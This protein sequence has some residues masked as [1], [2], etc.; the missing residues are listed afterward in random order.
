MRF[1]TQRQIQDQFLKV[2]VVILGLEI[3]VQRVLPLSKLF[4]KVEMDSE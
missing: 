4:L 1:Y 3:H 2:N